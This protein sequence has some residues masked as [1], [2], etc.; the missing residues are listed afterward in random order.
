MMEWRILQQ[1]DPSMTTS[2]RTALMSCLAPHL[3]LSKSRLETLAVFLMALIHGRTVNLTHA[4]SQFH[5]TARHASNYRRLQRFFQYVRLDQGV[6]ALIVVRMLNLSRPKCL[7]LDRTNWKVGSK[8]VNI[9]MLAIVT[10]RFRVPLLWS[11]LTHSGNSSSAQRIALMRRYLA[12]FDAASI[13]LLLADREFIG[14]EWIKFLIENDIPFAIRAKEDQRMAL[15]DGRLWSLKSLL[16][17]KRARHTTQTLDVFLPGT[18]IR[19]RLAARRIK[20]GEWL[21]IMTNSSE[22][23]RALQA[24]KRRWAVECLFA[25]TK[26]RGFNLE[27]TR[28]TNPAKVE[29]LTALVTLALTWVYRTASTE[30]RM[31]AIKR[32]SHGRREK[33]WFR[34]GF[35]ALRNHIIHQPKNAELA[36]TTACPKRFRQT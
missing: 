24:Y 12:L 9:L 34:I 21:I 14:A 16:R 5:G 27:D 18:L 10:R 15:A 32:K 31:A 29:T 23:K 6:I 30:M 13:E 2:L 26:T 25:D 35:D 36:W 17:T 4:A 33:S 19:L 28:L 3:G 7:A 1:K 20:D 11:V 8:D 22:P